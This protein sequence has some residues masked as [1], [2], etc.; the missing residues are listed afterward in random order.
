MGARVRARNGEVV[1][2]RQHGGS[3]RRTTCTPDRNALVIEPRKVGEAHLA[4]TENVA[5]IQTGEQYVDENIV[6]E[7]VDGDLLAC[8]E[9]SK[10]GGR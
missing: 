6:W 7:L 4:K 3:S 5:Q 1:S 10:D 9:E 2:I 8:S